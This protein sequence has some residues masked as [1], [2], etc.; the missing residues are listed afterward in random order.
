MLHKKLM[1]IELYSL[2][3][4]LSDL[5][6]DDMK[7]P[8][9]VGFKIL[10]NVKIL[11]EHVKTFQE[12]KGEIIKKYSKDG[13]V[14]VQEDDEGYAEAIEQIK[15]LESI[16]VDVDLVKLD[17]KEIENLQVPMRQMFALMELTEQEGEE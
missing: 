14:S 15:E 9:T 17:M 1:N 2:F 11:K 12:T 8:V 7:F 3:L 16:K 13:G 4:A 5:S 10:Q 6:R